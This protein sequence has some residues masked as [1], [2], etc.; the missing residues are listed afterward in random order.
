MNKQFVKIGDKEFPRVCD[1]T[2]I[3]NW[4]EVQGIPAETIN[5]NLGA[6]KLDGLIIKGYEMKWN[7]TNGNG[8]RYEQG[9]F[10]DFINEYFVE[11]GFNMPVDIN[12]EGYFNYKAVCGRVLYIETNSVGFYFVVYVPRWFEGYEDLKNRLRDGILQGFSKEGYAK[13]WKPVRDEDGNVQYFLIQKMVMLSVSIV[14]TPANGVQFEKMQEIKNGLV[15]V[16]K[17]IEDNAKRT[18]TLEAMFH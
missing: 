17:I 12:H 4:E 1:T 14:S 3:G 8:E 10:D 5:K 15:F 2:L 6:E 11:K 9:A 13:E 7:E 18:S 16:N